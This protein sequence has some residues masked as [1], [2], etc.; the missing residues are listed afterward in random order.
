M[1]WIR[2]NRCYDSSCGNYKITNEGD[3]VG[4]SKYV[5]WEKVNMD[6]AIPTGKKRNPFKLV[7]MDF[8]CRL[9]FMGTIDQC[10]EAIND[11]KNI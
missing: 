8:H 10:K 4:G 2:G 5:V 6:V 11:K 7:N 3:K 1:D 9:I